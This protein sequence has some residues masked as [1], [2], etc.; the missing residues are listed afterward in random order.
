MQEKRQ[1]YIK[2]SLDNNEYNHI[3]KNAEI[4]NKAMAVY[5]RDTLLKDIKKVSNA[6]RPPP[7]IHKDLLYQLAHIGNNINQIARALNSDETKALLELAQIIDSL[8][9]FEQIYLEYKQDNK[10]YDS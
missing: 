5:A 3:K 7:P 6:R 9:I 4:A 2:L 8:Q 10:F 1:R